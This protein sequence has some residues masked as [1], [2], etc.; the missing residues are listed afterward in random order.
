MVQHLA[1]LLAATSPET[2]YE[3]IR[4][5]VLERNVLQRPNMAGRTEMLRRLR[6]LYG[7]DPHIV[8]YRGLRVLWECSPAE[9]PLLAMMCALARDPV[10]Q[11][12]AGLIL[13]TPCGQPVDKQA[14]QDHLSRAFPSRYSAGVLAGMTRR[15]LSSWTQSGH[16]VGRSSKV[17]AA[18][19]A[20]PA[21][22]AYAVLLAYLEGARGNGIFDTMW[23]QVLDADNAALHRLAVDA[24]RRGW[25]DYFRAGTVVELR[26]SGILA[27]AV[28]KLRGDHVQSPAAP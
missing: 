9:Q 13:S 28:H 24:S 14:M 2:G 19:P 26:P 20:G 15:I 11:A 3:E 1:R 17:R 25:I 27:E 23:V 10:L 6:E 4:S 21:A 8:I 22:A 7:L 12:S 16:I 5:A 18:A